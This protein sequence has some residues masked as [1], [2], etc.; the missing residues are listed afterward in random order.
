MRAEPRL[1]LVVLLFAGPAACRPSRSGEQTAAPLGVAAKP[2]GGSTRDALPW[3]QRIGLEQ[4]ISARD[5]RHA[6]RIDRGAPALGT[7]PLVARFSVGGAEVEVGGH[8]AT[9]AATSINRGRS[10]S[11]ELASSVAPAI[12]GPEVRTD[13]GSGVVE[14]WRS[15]PSGL[16]HGLTLAERPA[17]EGE[18][19]VEIGIQGALAAQEISADAI[20]LVSADGA[21]VAT[22]A[23]LLV[24]DA[25]GARLQ[26]R[27]AVRD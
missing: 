21:R 27:M 6:P 15:L 2:A 20:A 24:L 25:A 9:L 7:G 26:A 17:G 13:H 4:A 23:H 5:A 22:Y 14:W 8:R 12:A 18:L 11:R 16:E 19:L 10:G 3:A 1:L